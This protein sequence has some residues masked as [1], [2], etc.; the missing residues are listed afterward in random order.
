MDL[1]AS[2]FGVTFEQAAVDAVRVEIAGEVLPVIGLGALR[3]N[4]KAT[5]RRKDR[6]DLKHLPTAPRS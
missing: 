5:Q 1:L 6:E 2:I 4:K 3:A